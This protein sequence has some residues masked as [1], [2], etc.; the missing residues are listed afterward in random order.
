MDFYG[1]CSSSTDFV[2]AGTCGESLFGMCESLWEP[3]LEPEDLFESI[4]Q[5]LL[6]SADRDTVSGW[7][8]VVYVM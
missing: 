2:L 3:D 8:A 5:A 6:N 4:S 7:G 1:C